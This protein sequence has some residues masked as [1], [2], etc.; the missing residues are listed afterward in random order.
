MADL[1]K[2][3]LPSGSEYNFKDAKAREDIEKIQAVKAYLGITTTAL[4]D[5]ATTSTIKIDGEDVTV[6]AKDAGAY[7]IYNELEFV[8]SGSKWQE[9]GSTSNLKDLA[10]KDE[11]SGK[12]TPT[13]QV[14]FTSTNKKASVAPG[15]GD[16]T[17]TPAGDVNLTKSNKTAAVSPAASGTATYT[18]AGSVNFTEETRTPTVSVK[19]AGATGTIHNP[20][21]ETVAKSVVAAAPGATAP[22]NPVTYY[23][24]SGETLSLYQ[25]GFT[26]GASITTDDVTVKTGDAA[27]EASGIAVPASASFSGTGVRLETGNIETVDSASFSG[28]GVHLETGNISTPD[29]ATFVGDEKTV[30]V[31]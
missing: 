1:S 26:T 22:A 11:A 23:E 24:V 21:A 3:T 30:T 25:L 6:A 8:W 7:V 19:T 15:S 2:I 5:G 16:A 12:V 13:G 20:T 28:T 9:L 18:P 29:S 4:T 14:N 27:Y 10:F 17:Y 31:S